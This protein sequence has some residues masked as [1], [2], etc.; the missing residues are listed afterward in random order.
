MHPEE[1]TD[2]EERTPAG[3]LKD[4][5]A[6]STLTQHGSKMDGV[7][8]WTR[9]VYDWTRP[10]FLFGRDRLVDELSPPTGG[11]VCEMGCG[12]AHNLIR[13]AR[14]RPDLQLLGVD[15]SE[16]MLEIAQQKVDRAGLSGQITLVHGFA[17]SYQP[18]A[19][20]HVVL[21][22]Y[23]LSMMPFPAQAMENAAS[24]LM[25]GGSLAVVDFGD[26]GRWP[27][28][29]RRPVL[30]FLNAF[31]VYPRPE[32]F[33]HGTAGLALQADWRMGRYCVAAVFSR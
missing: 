8:R 31:E 17:E 23:S 11:R 26:L 28:V 2:R 7:Y 6:Q 20:M 4:L 9:Y 3:D 29:L 15:A 5:P 16:A 30:K 22:P 14:R 33:E 10:F 1:Q 18:A 19:Q 12:T 25:P 32:L 21:F 27:S 24:W 13:L